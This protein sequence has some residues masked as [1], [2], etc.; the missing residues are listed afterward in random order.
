MPIF[1]V[2][3]FYQYT[4]KILHICKIQNFSDISCNAALASLFDKIS[5]FF[6]L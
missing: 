4:Q 2:L 1:H 5:G 6:L 3:F